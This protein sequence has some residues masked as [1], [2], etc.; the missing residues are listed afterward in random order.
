[1]ACLSRDFIF[2]KSTRKSKEILYPFTIKS[3][4]LKLKR[5]IYFNITLYVFRYFTLQNIYILKNIYISFTIGPNTL[6]S[7]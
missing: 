7:I 3:F 2:L 1:M 5:F 4:F 6:I